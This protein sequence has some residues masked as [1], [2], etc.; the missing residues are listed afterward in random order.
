VGGRF[1]TYGSMARGSQSRCSRTAS[2]CFLATTILV[3]FLLNFGTRTQN[4]FRMQHRGLWS[5]NQTVCQAHRLGYM[6]VHWPVPSGDEWS[7]EEDIGEDW[8]VN[9]HW[10]RQNPY[11]CST[12]KVLIRPYVDTVRTVEGLPRRPNNLR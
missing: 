8:R 6:K 12:Q 1:K 11:N 10:R 7:G 5:S 4:G 2:K 3:V 9:M